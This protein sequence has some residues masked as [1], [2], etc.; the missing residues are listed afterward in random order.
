MVTLREVAQQALKALESCSGVPHWSALRPTINDLR[1]ALAADTKPCACCGDGKASISV[2]RVCD[3]C[4]SEYAGQAEMGVA[5]RI[6]VEQQAE[7]VAYLHQCRKKKELRVLSFSKSIPELKAKGFEVLPLAHPQPA[8][9]PLTDEQ[10]LM[11]W[12]RATHDAD[13]YHKTKHQCLMDYGAEIEA[14]HDIK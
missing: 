3:T 9:Q 11:C 14:A 5:R 4:G 8:Q 13:V 10:K 1:Q 12:S 6:V 7:P 2:T